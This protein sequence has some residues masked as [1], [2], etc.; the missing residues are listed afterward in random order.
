MTKH[1]TIRL[2]PAPLFRVWNYGCSS[3]GFSDVRPKDAATVDRWTGFFDQEGC[4]VYE[5]DILSLHYDWKLGWVNAL[6][7]PGPNDRFVGKVIRPDGTV[8]HLGSFYFPEG[9]VEGNLRQHASK[10]VPAGKQFPDPADYIQPR[11]W[12]STIFQAIPTTRLN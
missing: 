11:L 4:P 7:E 8:F 5:N 6:V 1:P 2:E 9:Y 10:L 12:S 3:F